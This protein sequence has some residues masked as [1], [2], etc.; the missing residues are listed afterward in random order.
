MIILSNYRIRTRGEI[1]YVVS[2]EN[3]VCPKC[4]G[5]LIVRDSKRRQLI[6]VTGEVHPFLLRRLKCRQCN[7][8][9]LEL[10]DFF[11]PHKHYSRDVINMALNGAMAACPAEN[12]TIYRWN[13]EHAEKAL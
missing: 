13:K 5:P 8:L 2:Q 11:V 12:S 9:H 6:T 7:S 10:P 4:S 3:S 1:Y